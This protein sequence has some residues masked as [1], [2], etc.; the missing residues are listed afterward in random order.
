MMASSLRA[1]WGIQQSIDLV[2]QEMADPARSEFRRVQAE[3]RLGLSVEEALE[4]MA[5][6]LDSDD[7]RWTVT[8]IAIQ[9]EVGG[10]LAE[11][12]DLVAS[13]MR[14]RAELR[15]HIHALTSEGGS[16]LSFSSFCRSS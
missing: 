13:T 14:E 5:N 10:N 3:S 8:A 6:R 7:F 2:V 15:R 16:Q 4:K 9:R 12:L 11:V 1:G